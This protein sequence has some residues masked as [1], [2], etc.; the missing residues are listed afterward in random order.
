MQGETQPSDEANPPLKKETRQPGSDVSITGPVRL[1]NVG[2]ISAQYNFG[3]RL[4]VAGQ[5]L[6][7]GT[8]ML[9]VKRL[10]HG[11]PLVNSSCSSTGPGQLLSASLAPG[12]NLVNCCSYR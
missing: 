6:S 7:T 9:S 2:P 1:R 11:V 5:N 10:N 4:F 12:T 8:P 3:A